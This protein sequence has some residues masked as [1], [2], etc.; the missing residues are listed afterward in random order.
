MIRFV[1]SYTYSF[2]Y[3]FASKYILSYMSAC[4]VLTVLYDQSGLH[5]LSF[6]YA[7]HVFP[8]CTFFMYMSAYIHCFT[9]MH[10]SL[11]C[12]HFMSYLNE[13]S[14]VNMSAC[15]VYLSAFPVW[16]CLFASSSSSSNNGSIS[17]SSVIF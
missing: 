10:P 4:Y 11:T 17:F 6:S 8:A 2:L 3:V 5:A 13:I 15:T 7:F 9:I 12:L 1:S 14:F 16:P